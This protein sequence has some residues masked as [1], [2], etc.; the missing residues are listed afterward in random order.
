MVIVSH[1]PHYI[2]HYCDRACVLLQGCLQTFDDMGSA[3]SAYEA[4]T[5]PPRIG[6][7]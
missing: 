2:R 7:A 5:Q 4:Q 3:L 6:A 1:E